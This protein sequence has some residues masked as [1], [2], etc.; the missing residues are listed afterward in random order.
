MSFCPKCKREYQ[1]DIAVCPD[2]GGKLR[3]TSESGKFDDSETVLL[4]RT[5]DY[6]KAKFVTA[7]LEEAGVPY[8]GMRLDFSSGMAAITHVA[9]DAPRPAEIY[10]HPED[11]HRAEKLLREYEREQSQDGDEDA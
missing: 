6:L 5:V 4:L 1:D 10:V 8:R 9:Y 11:L 2:C 3:E 7:I